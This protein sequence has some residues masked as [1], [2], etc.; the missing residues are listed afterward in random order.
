MEVTDPLVLSAYALRLPLRVACAPF[1]HYPIVRLCEVAKSTECD[2]VQGDKR[3]F[4]GIYLGAVHSASA[5][6]NG[7]WE[8]RRDFPSQDVPKIELGIML[9]S[10]CWVGVS[11]ASEVGRALRKVNHKQ[12]ESF[13]ACKRAKVRE[14]WSRLWSNQVRNGVVE[15]WRYAEAITISCSIACTIESELPDT[16]IVQCQIPLRDD[17]PRSSEL[18]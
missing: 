2:L 7:N 14:T 10:S 6:P 9:C 11:M 3:T 15:W 16:M 18:W 17:S 1:L 4:S 8:H 13:F 12:S 5:F